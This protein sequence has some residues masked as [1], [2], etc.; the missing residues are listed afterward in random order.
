MCIFLP[1]KCKVKF[2]FIIWGGLVMVK[3][4]WFGS[5][6]GLIQSGKEQFRFMSFISSN[7]WIQDH[8]IGTQNTAIQQ[9]IYSFLLHVFIFI[10]THSYIGHLKMYLYNH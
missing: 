8:I 9:F 5:S 6:L 7:S 1:W 4:M 2:A 3:I 10:S